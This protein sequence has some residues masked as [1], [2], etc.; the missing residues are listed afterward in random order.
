VYT[1]LYRYYLA[2]FNDED[3]SARRPLSWT[4][5]DPG[6]L[7]S[8]SVSAAF[9][10]QMNDFENGKRATKPVESDIYQ[11]FFDAQYQ[12]RDNVQYDAPTK[13]WIIVKN[14]DPRWDFQPNGKRPVFFDPGMFGRPYADPHILNKQQP[15]IEKG[16]W[17]SL[18]FMIEAP[19]SFEMKTI[20][21][22]N[23]FTTTPGEGAG[24]MMP[25]MGMPGGMAPPPGP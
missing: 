14:P 5:R 19:N 3:K 12:E 18:S 6:F 24:G 17:P 22:G 16:L 8:G 25:V 15:T 23:P 9:G 11:Q 2:H 13:S 1:L 4:I 10:A 21:Q 7:N 20:W